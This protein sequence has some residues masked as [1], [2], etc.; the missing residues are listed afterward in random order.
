VEQREKEFEKQLQRKT[1][2]EIRPMSNK[3]STLKYFANYIKRSYAH[4]PTGWTTYDRCLESYSLMSTWTRLAPANSSKSDVI[5][6]DDP[7]SILDAIKKKLKSISNRKN[8][9]SHAQSKAASLYSSF[10]KTVKR[11]KIKNLIERIE[12]KAKSMKIE[13]INDKLEIA[14]DTTLKKESNRDYSENSDDNF[15]GPGESSSTSLTKTNFLIADKTLSNDE[16]EL[17]NNLDATND[18]E[19]IPHYYLLYKQIKTTSE[20]DN[21]SFPSTESLNSESSTSDSTSQ[22]INL[23]ENDEFVNSTQ[24]IEV[25]FD[26]TFETLAKESLVGNGEWIIGSGKINVRELLKKWKYEK[27]RPHNE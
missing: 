15:Q 7:E 9:L 10:D 20:N 11:T 6:F 5:D 27:D 3:V 25:M 4:M 24:D 1:E 17:T 14:S 21:G 18:K 19:R 26:N 22:I 12:K 2:I 13:N 23:D 8:L 16:I